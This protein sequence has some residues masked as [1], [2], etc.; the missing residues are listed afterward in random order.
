M[1]GTTG[2]RS[3]SSSHTFSSP[4][5]STLLR[6]LLALLK[7]LLSFSRFLHLFGWLFCETHSLAL[8]QCCGWH[9]SCALSPRFNR[10]SDSI[11]FRLLLFIVQA[12]QPEKVCIHLSTSLFFPLAKSALIFRILRFPQSAE[13]LRPRHCHDST[14]FCLSLVLPAL[15]LVLNC[16]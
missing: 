1:L 15:A 13:S 3:S 7:F 10:S 12:R 11:S 9:S 8:L 4:V 16:G 14:S 5:L 6:A 2:T